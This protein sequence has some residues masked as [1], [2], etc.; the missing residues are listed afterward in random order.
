TQALNIGRDYVLT[1]LNHPLGLRLKRAKGVGERVFIDGNSAAALG[2]VYGGATVAAWDPITASTPPAHAL[3][4][5]FRRPPPDPGSG[6]A[7]SG[8]VAAEDELASIGMVIG[9]AWN[10]ARAFTSPS[11]PGISLMQEFI[12]LAYSRR[13]R[14]SS[15]TSSAAAPP[16]ACPRARSN[17][18]S[19][20]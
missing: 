1:Q 3:L 13:C 19:S 9:A 4:R 6:K 17:R 10:G 12:G 7:R 11:G 8:R 20:P 16:R 14:P 5:L 18:T 15:S 2:C